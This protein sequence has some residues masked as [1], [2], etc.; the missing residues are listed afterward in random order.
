MSTKSQMTFS[1]DSFLLGNLSL[2]LLPSPLNDGFH[3]D[4]ETFSISMTFAFSCPYQSCRSTKQIINAFSCDFE[5]VFITLR[6]A[7]VERR[8][9][10]SVLC[11]G[12]F[13]TRNDINPLMIY[14]NRLFLEIRYRGI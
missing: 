14:E 1:L 3:S 5:I 4:P 6:T 7:N 12:E 13:Y 9:Y 11:L 10:T 2:S 8:I